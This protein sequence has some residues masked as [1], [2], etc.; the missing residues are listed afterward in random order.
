MNHEEVGT[1]ADDAPTGL[2]PARAPRRRRPLGWPLLL[3]MAVAAVAVI[4]WRV[5]SRGPVTFVD[6]VEI[7]VPPYAPVDLSQAGSP[8]LATIFQLGMV[9]FTDGDWAAACEQL[10]RADRMLQADPGGGPPGQPLFGP[11]LRMYLGVALLKADRT[12]EALAVLDGLSAPEVALPLRERGL[13]Y[14][15][16]ARLLLGDGEGAAHQLDR[17]NGSPVYGRTAPALAA[18]L[19]ERLGR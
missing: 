16:Q 17:L 1:G 19:R 11:L 7:E 2:W 15:A 6:L 3:L 14:G 4:A 8:G 10:A 12:R 9:H 18:R 13:W 5:Q